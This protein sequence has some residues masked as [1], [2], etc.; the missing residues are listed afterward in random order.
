MEND[1]KFDRT[2]IKYSALLRGKLG[3]LKIKIKKTF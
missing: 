1:Y 3:Y 2:M